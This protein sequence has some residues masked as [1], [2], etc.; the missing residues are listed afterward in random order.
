[1]LTFQYQIY[2]SVRICS[3]RLS[4]RFC[5]SSTQKL[6]LIMDTRSELALSNIYYNIMIHRYMYLC[7]AYD[8]EDFLTI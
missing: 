1:M 7:H 5:L 2:P 6:S 4:N 3:K 8:Y